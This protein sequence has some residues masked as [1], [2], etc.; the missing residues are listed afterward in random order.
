ML[1]LRVFSLTWFAVG[2]P[3]F[4][5]SPRRTWVD[6]SSEPSRVV[7]SPTSELALLQSRSPRF[8]FHG[9]LWKPFRGIPRGQNMKTPRI[10]CWILRGII[11]NTTGLRGVFMRFRPSRIAMRNFLLNLNWVQ[12]IRNIKN[13]Y[14][15]FQFRKY[16]DNAAGCYNLP[17]YEFCTCLN[18]QAI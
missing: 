10:P 11:M 17:I 12:W 18:V 15:N 8:I 1:L 3:S 9:I 7:P 2:T 16:Q 14:I 4:S 13:K 6:I 5:S